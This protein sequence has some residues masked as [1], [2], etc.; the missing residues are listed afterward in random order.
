MLAVASVTS[1]QLHMEPGKI[2]MEKKQRYLE[3]HFMSTAYV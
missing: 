3:K 2:S 1:L